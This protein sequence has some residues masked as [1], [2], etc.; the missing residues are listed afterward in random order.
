[1][2]F[3]LA[4]INTIKDPAWYPDELLDYLFTRRVRNKVIFKRSLTG[5]NSEF[6]SYM[7][8]CHIMVKNVQ[9]ILLL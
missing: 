1:M 9:S 8:G 4:L 7:I 2:R 6:Y 5:L 3:A